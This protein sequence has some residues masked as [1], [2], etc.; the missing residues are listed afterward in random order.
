[1][2]ERTEMAAFIETLQ[3]IRKHYPNI[4]VS[5]VDAIWVIDNTQVSWNTDDS[6]ED[7]AYQ[8]GNSYS[9]LIPENYK[10]IGN[11]TIVNVD[12]GTGTW[13]TLIFPSSKRKTVAELEE[14]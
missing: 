8:E 11:Y 14:V 5:F 9:A 13:E 4:L 12:T 3:D 7:L 1:M 2:S 10:E 6:L